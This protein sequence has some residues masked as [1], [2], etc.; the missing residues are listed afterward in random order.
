MKTLKVL[1][2]I[3]A[4]ALFFSHNASGQTIQQEVLVT[5]DH[6]NLDSA[7]PGLGI[8][9]GTYT[10]KLGLKLTKEGYI[11]GLS[12]HIKDCDLT[13]DKGD[14]V[15][16]VDSGHDNLGILWDWFNNA[17]YYNLIYY[18]CTEIVYDPGDG[19]L[20]DYLP[21]VWPS[22]G[23]TAEMSCKLVCKGVIFRISV[24]VVVHCNANGEMVV[25]FVKP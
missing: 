6:Y 9:T 5:M 22:E 11:E 21:P 3:F 24:L 4:C 17:N 16:I 12:Y 20:N 18:N 2:M 7:C 14:K 15:I 8:V 25:N 23:V 1:I 13:N 10:Y 19:W